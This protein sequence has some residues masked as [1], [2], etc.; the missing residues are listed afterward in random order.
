MTM[1]RDTLQ[2]MDVGIQPYAETLALQEALV[3]ERKADR[4]SDTL[5]FVEHTPVYTLG[6]NA[7][8]ANILANADELAT[9]GIDVHTTGRGGD[10]T[11][12][13][14][15]QLVGYPIMRLRFPEQGP[16][17]YV[18]KLEQSL[19]DTLATF[20][21]TAGTDKINRGV[22]VGQDKIAAIGVRI[23]QHVTMHGFALNVSTDLSYYSG[24]VPCGIHERGVTTLE[25]ETQ[26][27]TMPDVK[28]TFLD[29]FVGHFG[30]TSVTQAKSDK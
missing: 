27:I 12:H 15:G 11:F 28:R 18:S 19:I 14:P 9:R 26:N 23:T 2:V 6:R 22:W 20:G 13:G 4:V 21:V 8:T 7:D 25:R 29:T 17:W 10:V 30:Y 3:L 16:V 1:T 5:I 24:I